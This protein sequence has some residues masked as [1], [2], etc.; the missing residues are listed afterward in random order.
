MKKTAFLINTSRGGLIDE[1][2]LSN[3][4]NNNLIK[5]AGLDVLST[6]PPKENNPLLKSKNTTITPHIAWATLE[7]RQRV[8][9]ETAKN[10]ESFLKEEDR[11]IVI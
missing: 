5:G 9:N 2:A 1:Q 8:L 3:V 4:L 7:A 6:E 11:N 10:I